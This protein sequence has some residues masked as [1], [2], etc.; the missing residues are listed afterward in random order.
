MYSD[1]KEIMMKKC[2]SEQVQ[3]C[4]KQAKRTEILSKA[5]A[6]LRKAEIKKKWLEIIELKK[7]KSQNWNTKLRRS[8][9][10]RNNSV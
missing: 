5:L 8:T 2:F 6:Q 4:L 1:F 9:Q 3:T 10:I 7:K